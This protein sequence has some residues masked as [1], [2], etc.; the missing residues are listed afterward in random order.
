M[1]HTAEADFSDTEKTPKSL[2]EV[3][4]EAVALLC[5]IS[6]VEISESGTIQHLKGYGFIKVFK[7]VAPDGDI[8][9]WATNKVEMSELERVKFNEMAWTIETYHRSSNFAE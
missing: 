7:L 2:R 9:Y 1:G 8:E 5:C 4:A 3:E 6:E